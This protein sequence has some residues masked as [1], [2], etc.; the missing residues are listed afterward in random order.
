MLTIPPK[1]PIR[2][3][4]VGPADVVVER[5][6]DGVV[7][8]RS[9]HALGPYPDKLTERLA[10]WAAAAPD[11][12]L[13]AKRDP[14]AG[15]GGGWLTITYRQAL[16]AARR[17]GAAL[18]QRN[19]SADR[20]VMI[21]SGNDIEHALLG[22]GVNYVGI[23]YA[24]VSPAYS[25]ISTDFGKLRHVANL[26]TPGLVFAADGAAFGRAIDAVVP[27][28]VEVMVTKNPALSGRPASLFAELMA[29]NA[30]AA[31]DAAHA[32]VGP[33]TI[34]KFLLT[35]GSTGTP[36]AVINTQRMWCAN[37]EMLRTMLAYFSDEPPVIVDW[38]PWHHTAGGNHD[39]GLVIYNGGTIYIDD[40][41]PAPGAIEETVRNLRDVAPNWYFN[42]PKGFE[43]LLPFL[44]GDARLRETF[45]SRL[46]VL[47][48]A[49]AG[50][51]QHVF[52]EMKDLAVRTCGEQILFLTGLGATETA[53][54]ALC[55]TW[56]IDNAA[57]VG[58]PPPGL[59]VKLVPMQEKDDAKY[60][61]RLRGPNITPGYWRDATLTAAAFD[62]EG[63]YRLGDAF[64]FHDPAVPGK[65]LLF[66]GR[67]AEDFKLAT[68]T[69]V[70]VGPLRVAFIAHFA[71]FV[72]DV[73]IAGPERDAL[74]ALALPDIDACR[75]L[76]PHLDG[77][78]P[79]D[80]LL[81]DPQVRREFQF[82]L[83]AF[84]RQSTGSSNRIA[85]M[86]FLTVP[87]SLDAG[88]ITDKGSINQRAVLRHRA[89]TVDALY[90]TPAP[91][92][93]IAVDSQVD[94]AGA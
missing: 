32:A 45:F 62:E 66:E 38:A 24:P 23:P 68:G 20:P 51:G 15:P 83:G 72:R 79:P 47:W 12:V 4:R 82:L 10:F 61:A 30:T 64:R 35:S 60:E 41:R 57:N 33:N 44:R 39:V 50:I 73:V 6:A 75:R 88:E 63:F 84:A 11:R 77:D 56:D 1:L 93:V 70:H 8:L 89:A 65:G 81:A 28:D 34:A 52:D 76:A 69:W 78:T 91:A 29:D 31:A 80:A 90:A 16:D 25:L 36:K 42:V 27:P 54:F 43:A 87:P 49:G 94:K 37:Q 86:A 17:I 14:A 85:R 22:L 92:W 46:K 55:R 13:F 3:V 67:I 71:P 5:R 48:F 74:A 19:L 59:D 21:L 40:G 7:V 53:P 58:L 2:H 26:L 9:P 18:L